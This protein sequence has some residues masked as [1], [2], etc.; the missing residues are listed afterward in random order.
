MLKMLKGLIT[1]PKKEPDVENDAGLK[2][3][4]EYN[5]RPQCGSL[6]AH[7]MMKNKDSNH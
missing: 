4:K 7:W 5:L 2:E 6:T 1:S 3:N